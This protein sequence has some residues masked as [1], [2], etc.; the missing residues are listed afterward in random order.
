MADIADCIRG[1]D[2]AG[3]KVHSTVLRPLIIRT[4]KVAGMGNI[5]LDNGGFQGQQHMDHQHLFPHHEVWHAG[6]DN[7]SSEVAA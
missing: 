2:K 5:L 7:S 3:M 1:Q 4:I 6:Q